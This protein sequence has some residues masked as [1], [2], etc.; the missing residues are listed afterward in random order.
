[1]G[2]RATT[3]ISCWAGLL[4]LGSLFGCTEAKKV[5]DVAKAVA[6][7]RAI[8]PMHKRLKWKAEDFFSDQGV[9]K[10][11]KAIEARDLKEIQRLVKSGVDVNA[12]GRGNVTPLLWAFPMGEDVFRTVLELGA[13][14]N[15]VLTENYLLLKGKSVVFACV[16]LVDG[17]M[18][19]Q[20]FYDVPMD[21]YLKLVLEHG[22]NP[23]AEDQD[24]QTPLFAAMKYGPHA[25]RKIGE[26]TR[27]GADLNHMDN[28]GYPAVYLAAAGP[29]DSTLALLEAGADYRIPAP[30]GWD[31]VVSL[32]WLI[33]IEQRL[34]MTDVKMKQ[35]QAVFDWL[36]KEGV[37]WDA[38]HAA[39]T[40][41][42]VMKNIKN[43]P[44]D[45]Q[46]RPWLPQRP[47]LKKADE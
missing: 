19:S 45:Y 10:L 22:G 13:D 2:L 25:A 35:V 3:G 36:T 6:A 26:L 41:K 21:N 1:M 32:E 31:L 44:A 46:H 47:T 7:H 8:G 28:R 33:K 16:E 42:D 20:L 30:N 34:I 5:A 27:C 17:L 24:G 38:A 11:C 43:L 39:L 37:N 15:V 18:Y 14:P 23:N 9:I 40:D 4:L 12:R 29:Y